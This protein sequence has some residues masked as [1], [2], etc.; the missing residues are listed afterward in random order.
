MQSGSAFNSWALNENPT[1]TANQYAKAMGVQKPNVKLIVEYLKTRPA[2]EILFG[3]QRV[4]VD[5]CI[6]IKI[7]FK[8]SM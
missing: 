3:I 6:H 8:R 4:G 5:V 7:L 1:D 2:S